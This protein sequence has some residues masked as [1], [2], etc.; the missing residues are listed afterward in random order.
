M[1]YNT[2]GT[3]SPFC[4]HPIFLAPLHL[5]DFLINLQE[6]QAGARTGKR[7]KSLAGFH[8]LAQSKGGQAD[9]PWQKK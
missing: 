9:F 5:H 4:Q 6:M 3:I 2:L 8:Y 7:W 1:A